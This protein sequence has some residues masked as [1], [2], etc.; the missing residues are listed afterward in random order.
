MSIGIQNGN[1]YGQYLI[2][3]TLTPT[4]VSASRTAGQNFTAT[5]FP[6][7]A[8]V[9]TGDFIQVNSP[10]I[11]TGVNVTGARVSSAG[12]V[13]MYFTNATASL[14]TPSPGV[15]QFLITRPER[16]VPS[17]TIGD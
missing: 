1:V 17:S 12:V 16:Q 15:Y 9:R 10:L 4:A 14:T 5:Q 6:A 11:T 13:T 2:Q 7:L 8:N 3:A